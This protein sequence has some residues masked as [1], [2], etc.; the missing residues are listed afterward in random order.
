MIDL[1]STALKEYGTREIVGKEHNPRILEYFAEIGHDWVKDDE[2]AWCSAFVNFVAKN[3]GY[4]FTGKLNA[5]SWLD[6]G[7]AITTPELGSVVVLYR[8]GK[9]SPW[10]HVGLFIREHN[11]WIFILGGNQSNEVNISPYRSERLLSYRKLKK[12]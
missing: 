11:G 6:I 3:T 4:E 2:L 12:V 5:R 1:L 7:E 9:E 10:G 8:N